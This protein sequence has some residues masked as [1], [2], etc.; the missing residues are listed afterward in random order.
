MALLVASEANRSGIPS[1]VGFRRP[2]QYSTTR[3]RI[4]YQGLA[5]IDI[6]QINVPI[7]GLGLLAYTL[8]SK[9]P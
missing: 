6:V 3:S 9:K 4:L 8:L 7:L 5:L 1:L 2:H